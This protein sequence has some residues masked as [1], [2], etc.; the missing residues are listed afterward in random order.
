V[1]G[2]ARLRDAGKHVLRVIFPQDVRRGDAKHVD[3]VAGEP[4]I[5]PPVMLQLIRILM[6]TPV[7]LDREPH[8][9]TIEIENVRTD[10][11]LPPE[12]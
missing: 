5:A 10:L 3:L 6:R 8:S 4:L 11:M 2:A 7:D 9:R 12:L 1:E